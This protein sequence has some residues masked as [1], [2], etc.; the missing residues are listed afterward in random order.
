MCTP[1]GGL[2]FY[3]AP[4]GL[5]RRIGF[6]PKCDWLGGDGY[7]VVPLSRTDTGVYEFLSMHDTAPCLP[8]VPHWLR[9]L[10]Y[11]PPPPPRPYRVARCLSGARGAGHP[12]TECAD[13]RRRGARRP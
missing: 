11:P 12:R 13:L 2:H 5:G 9:D 6:V 4:A 8:S 7:V 3:F 10:V 1:S